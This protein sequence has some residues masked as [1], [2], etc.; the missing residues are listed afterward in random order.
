MTGEMRDEFTGEFT[1]EMRDELSA[2]RISHRSAVALE[3]D[4]R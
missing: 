4:E 3:R 1:G 2:S